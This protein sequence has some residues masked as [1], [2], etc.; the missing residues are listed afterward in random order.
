MPNVICS[1]AAPIKF[2]SSAFNSGIKGLN[3]ENNFIHK[4]RQTFHLLFTS[5]IPTH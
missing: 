4:T 5:W 3:K 1:Y 2:W